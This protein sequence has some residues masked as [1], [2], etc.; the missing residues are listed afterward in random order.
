VHPHRGSP[1]G[2]SQCEAPADLRESN[3][4]PP[5][6]PLLQ[7]PLPEERR[8]GRRQELEHMTTD[9]ARI[10]LTE[11]LAHLGPQCD[12]Q[13]HRRPRVQRHLERLPKLGIE[14]P[15]RP[16]EKLRQQRH[17][18]GRRNRKHLRRALKEPEDRGLSQ[19]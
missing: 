8:P 9:A 5:A 12:Q 4:P 6:E 2:S 16:P 14:L 7:R 13:C 11:N 1:I 10:H 3:R 19:A 15:V 17:V 18:T